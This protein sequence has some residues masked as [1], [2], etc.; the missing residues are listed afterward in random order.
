MTVVLHTRSDIDLDAAHRVAWLGEDV[1]LAPDALE[2]MDRAHASLLEYIDAA[3]AQDPGAL[4][5]GITTAPGD[6]AA[7]ALTAEGLARRP[8]RLWTALSFGEPLPERVVRGIL[9]ARLANLIDGHAGVRGALG[10]AIAGML[11][12]RPL[13]EV[14]GQGNGG[15][16]EILALGR[17]FFDF[18]ATHEL[19]AKERMALINGSPCAAALAA[20]GALAGRGRLA[21]VEQVLALSAEAI[22]APHEAYA[23]ELE[24]LWGDEH[25]T[26]ALRSLRAH[27]E[28]GSE[29]REAHQAPVSYRILPRV[30]GALRRAQAEAERAATVSLRSVSDNPLYLPPDD[31]RPLG[32]V[33]ST[34][35]YHNAQASPALDGLATAWADICQLVQ[36]HTDKL[37]QHPRTLP[38]LAQ[39]EW[40]F[41]PLHMVQAGWAEEARALAQPTLLGL[42]GFGQNDVPSPSFLAWR[43][44]TG[45]GRCLDGALAG[46]ATIAWQVLRSGTGPV[47][48]ALRTLGAQVEEL[49]PAPDGTRPI[50]TDVQALA[51]A[52][53]D[54]VLDG[55]A[56]GQPAP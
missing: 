30:L 1:A 22:G 3:V 16:G 23:A 7:T 17:L 51:D 14:P 20:D 12:G 15:A 39:E 53:A 32:A 41:K 36:R 9:L 6:G 29:Q 19:S 42:G 47:P 50:G 21:L 31:E 48:P 33:I 54:R 38:A 56:A 55:A 40:T 46:L 26:A 35:G 44:A 13:P 18:S 2:R 11:D 45:V 43:K 5:Y 28:G 24:E 25:E 27:L 10:S 49:V 52:F 34:G 37:F 4:I 8:T